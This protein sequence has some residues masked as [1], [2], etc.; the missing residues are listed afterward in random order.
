[1]SGLTLLVHVVPDGAAWVVKV[2]GQV[3]TRWRKLEQAVVSA[4]TY[5]RE[6]GGGEVLIRNDQHTVVERRQ[7]PPE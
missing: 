2:R 7:I 5:A 4:E 1:M 6:R 3:Q